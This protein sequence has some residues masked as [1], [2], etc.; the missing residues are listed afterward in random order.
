MHPAANA[1]ALMTLIVPALTFLYT[2]MNRS[3]YH[4]KITFRFIEQSIVLVTFPCFSF[5]FQGF[6][7][8]WKIRSYKRLVSVQQNQFKLRR[9]VLIAI[10][11]CL[12]QGDVRSRLPSRAPL[13][14]CAVFGTVLLDHWSNVLRRMA[15][16]RFPL[17]ARGV[18]YSDFHRKLYSPGSLRLLQRY[19]RKAWTETTTQILAKKWFW[20]GYTVRHDQT[21]LQKRHSEYCYLERVF[22]GF[23]TSPKI[24]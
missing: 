14:C 13:L 21:S 3:V 20:I 10:L 6:W 2:E 22:G 5:S 17:H 11:L 4:S 12:L 24:R 8:S 23:I 1:F 18:A 7:L 15:L 19:G 16:C 9:A